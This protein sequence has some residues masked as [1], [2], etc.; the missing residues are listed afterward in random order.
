MGCKSRPGLREVMQKSLSRVKRK[1][2]FMLSV[3][4][5]RPLYPLSPL[6]PWNTLLGPLLSPAQPYPLLSLK[7]DFPNSRAFFPGIPV[8]K[9]WKHSRW[10]VM[11]LGHTSACNPP[12]CAVMLNPTDTS[13]FVDVQPSSDSDTLLLLTALD[14]ISVFESGD[15]RER[16]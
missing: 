10:P 2:H 4:H 9:L 8:S 11:V 7:R 16:I 6:S 14:L 5:S 13:P 12:S 3:M 1:T 15:V